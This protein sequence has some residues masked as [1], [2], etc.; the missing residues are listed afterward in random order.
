MKEEKN[1]L[2]EKIREKLYNH[3]AEVPEQLWEGISKGVAAKG[4]G[5]T[6]LFWKLGMYTL[7][8]LAL[9]IGFAPLLSKSLFA[10]KKASHHS[11]IIQDKNVI[12][13]IT[14]V[15]NPSK[16]SEQQE[17]KIAESSQNQSSHESEQDKNLKLREHHNAVHA[18]Q[19]ELAQAITNSGRTHSSSSKENPAKVLIPL[20]LETRNRTPKSK[21][22]KIVKEEVK[23]ISEKTLA[24]SEKGT[25][26]NESSVKEQQLN[27]SNHVDPTILPAT[28]EEPKVEVV[29]PA[30]NLTP[31]HDGTP[32]KKEIARLKIDE[33]DSTSSINNVIVAETLPIK[34]ETLVSKDS[35]SGK[36]KIKNWAVE[37]FASPDFYF[38][39]NSNQNGAS[40]AGRMDSAGINKKAWSVGMLASYK[41]SKNWAMALS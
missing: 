14:P 4:A 6:S 23:P 32:E 34:N 12:Q 33:V 40:L 1:K 37:I 36:K 9:L 24:S 11:E 30:Q 2:E 13:E 27:I 7:I 10:E 39:H 31:Q 17:Q 26:Q 15:K 28:S 41:L 16:T 29:L 25:S 19:K 35:T 8:D 5:T 18:Q 20:A 38:L 21:N 3:S 22:K